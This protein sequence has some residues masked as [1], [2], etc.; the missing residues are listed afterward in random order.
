MPKVSVIIPVYNVEQYLEEC[1]DSVMQ[2][3]YQDIEIICIDDCSTDHSIDILHKYEQ[4]DKRIAVLQNRVNSG[5]AFTRNVGIDNA[6]GE[7]ILFVDSDDYIA[8]N[9]LESVLEKA[10]GNDIVCYDYR[11]QDEIYNGRD[12]HKYSVADG[13]FDKTDYFINAVMSNSI[14]YS[15]WSKVYSSAFLRHNMI[16]FNDGIFYEDILFCFQCLMKAER[17]YSINQKLYYYRIRNDSIMTKKISQKNIEDY[18][19]NVY[20]LTRYYIESDCNEVLGNAIERYIQGVCRDFIKAY[21]KYMKNNTD[22]LSTQYIKDNIC[23]KLYRIFPKFSIETGSIGDFTENQ[24]KRISES[25]Y[26]IIYGAGD[27]AREIIELFDRNDIPICGIAVSKEENNHRSIL[28]N[29]VLG[30]D[31]YIKIRDESIVIVATTPRYY[32]E[33]HKILEMQGF[34]NYIEVL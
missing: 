18:F 19:W 29:R 30:I 21:R 31:K 13:L 24:W 4:R 14:I 34:K 1:L 20:Q 15:A 33:I 2:Q 32:A 10:V 7:Y 27:I 26:V 28:G 22:Y 8:D 25:K 6:T 9:L 23:A 3:T 17:V 16:R 5:L 11:K 12:G